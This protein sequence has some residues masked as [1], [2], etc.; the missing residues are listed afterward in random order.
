[1]GG[2]NVP[3]RDL[4]I[5]Y[6][7]RHYKGD[8]PCAQNR[9][10]DGCGHY[11]PFQGRILIIKIGALG[12]VIRTLC[13]LPELR[14]RHPHSQITWLTSP[15]AA[16]FIAGHPLIDRII[17]FDPFTALALTHERFHTLINLDKESGPCGLAMSI[18][19]ATKLGIGLSEVGTPI[20]LN[21]QAQEFFQLGL[22]DELK[23]RQNTRSYPHLVHQALGFEYTG[24]PYELPVA[25]AAIQAVRTR[26]IE[27]GWSPDRPTLGV[28]VGAGKVFAN[29]MWTPQRTE[30]LLAQLHRRHA[31]WQVMLVGGLEEKSALDQL[32]AALPW[33]IHT[34]A[35]NSA[36][37]LVALIDQIDTLFSGDTLTMHLAI[38]RRRGTVVFFGPTCEQEIDLF[39]LGEKLVA[40]TS[41]SPCYKRTCDRGDVCLSAV[42]IDSALLAIDRVMNHRL[43]TAGRIAPSEI[44]RAG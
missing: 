27:V 37:I 22:S 14:R 11:Q 40:S 28:N 18:P 7:C 33:T 21:T 42:S 43:A 8:R 24:Q 30:Q 32:H 34:G 44:R 19:A 4:N 9:L 5:L 12:D 23:F 29:K 6:D 1:M 39:G 38:A 35:D 36:A 25:P 13:L 41:C 10:C 15:A 16:A 31:D 3:L 26:L 17:P 2:L 20:P